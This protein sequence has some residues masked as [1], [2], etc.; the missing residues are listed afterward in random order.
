MKSTVSHF[1]RRLMAGIMVTAFIMPMVAGGLTPAK[2]TVFAAY[3]IWYE[4]GTSTNRSWMMWSNEEMAQRWG[5]N[6]PVGKPGDPPLLSSAYP[7]AGLYSSS[8]PEVA[9][10]HIEVAKAAGIDAF[11]VSWWGGVQDRNWNF[12]HAILPMAE[13]HGF[14]IALLDEL[15]QFHSDQLQYQAGLTTTLR[16]YKDSPAYLRID[17][18]PVVYLYQAHPPTLTPATFTSL[19]AHVEHEVGPVYWI[20]DQIEHNGA[21]RQSEEQKRI[22]PGWLTVPGIDAFAFYATFSNFRADT[23]DQLVGKY[24]YLAA[25]AHQAG[26]KMVLPVHPGHNNS[27]F[28]KDP[29]DMPRRDGQTFRDFLKAATEAGADAILVTSWNEWPETTVIEPSETWV[30]SYQY[31]KILA[32]WKGVSFKQPP[33]P[34]VR[35]KP[36]TNE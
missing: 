1:A 15:A 24:R 19:R 25:T 12:E 8:D 30:D 29:Y 36:E 27:R 2:P 14:K 7:L 3:Y 10:W 32:E 35:P 16:K 20:V 6:K 18:R 5:T 31:V 22:P 17:G 28:S 23:Y 33:G 13:K 9:A 21:A 11:L 34:P 4:S 26:R